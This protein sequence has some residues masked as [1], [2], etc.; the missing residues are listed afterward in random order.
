MKYRKG[1]IKDRFRMKKNVLSSESREVE[2]RVLIESAKIASS[3]AVRSSMALGITIKII[4]EHQIIAINPDKTRNVIRRISKPT[5]DISSLQK[6][7]V[8]ER[9]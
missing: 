6:G 7:M 9:K 3:K 4:E 8:L 5:V 1:H 2:D